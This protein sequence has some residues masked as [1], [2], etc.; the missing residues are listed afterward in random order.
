MRGCAR[1][2]SVTACVQRLVCEMGC[3]TWRVRL[4][5]NSRREGGCGR[6]CR[7]EVGL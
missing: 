2:G 6:D 7:K 5:G 1:Q 4:W 3:E